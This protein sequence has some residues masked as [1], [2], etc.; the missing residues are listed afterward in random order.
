MK[1]Q[2]EADEDQE[3]EPTCLVTLFRPIGTARAEGANHIV[4]REVTNDAVRDL[5]PS[6]G[7][8][9]THTHT[10]TH[11]HPPTHTHTLTLACAHSQPHTHISISMHGA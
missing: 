4:M 7:P 5:P 9:L 2:C 6:S 10:H 11:M 3:V 1:Q 8:T